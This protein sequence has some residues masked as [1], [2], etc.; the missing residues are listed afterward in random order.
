MSILS[1]SLPLLTY[2][3]LIGCPSF[4]LTS[5]ALPLLK[6]LIVQFPMSRARQ[7]YNPLHR[8]KWCSRLLQRL[9]W[10]YGPINHNESYEHESCQSIEYIQL[11]QLNVLLSISTRVTHL[12]LITITSISYCQ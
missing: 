9:D 7:P 2:V 4:S 3:E 11:Q 12:S 10:R 6:T 1:T 8:V 5:L